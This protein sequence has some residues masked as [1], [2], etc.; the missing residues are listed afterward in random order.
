MA[1]THDT[2]AEQG[3]LRNACGWN[4]LL[5]TFLCR[6]RLSMGHRIWSINCSICSYHVTQTPVQCTLFHSAPDHTMQQHSI[7]I[8]H[9]CIVCIAQ[10]KRSVQ[11]HN[12]ALGNW[13]L[14]GLHAFRNLVEHYSNLQWLCV[15][16]WSF[17][18]VLTQVRQHLPC[19]AFRIG[20]EWGLP[21]L[22]LLCIGSIPCG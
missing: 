20:F 22:E 10:S 8:H 18:H 2:R 15:P 7:T 17:S 6:N 12:C 5:T 4:G 13:N 3:R 19:S 9:G 21:F 1:S 11:E 16:F 14:S